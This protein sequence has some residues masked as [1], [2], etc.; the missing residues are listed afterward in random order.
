MQHCKRPLCLQQKRAN[1]KI[2]KN[3]VGYKNLQKSLEIALRAKRNKKI[4]K[5][6]MSSGKS[7]T[8]ILNFFVARKANMQH[9]KKTPKAHN[10]LQ[11][12]QTDRP[13][14]S[15]E[16][17]RKAKP[18]VETCLPSANAKRRQ[19]AASEPAMQLVKHRRHPANVCMYVYLSMCEAR[20]S[21]QVNWHIY[22][23]AWAYS[24]T[25]R[26]SSLCVYACVCLW[27]EIRLSST[28]RLV[29]FW[30]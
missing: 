29:T 5:K 24:S 19:E 6:K 7:K 12:R 23:R 15:S 2:N 10:A 16:S 25:Q 11:R 9:A 28:A 13:R 18:A 21:S 17:S 22:V 14:S 20:N 26:T 27:K 30:R 1:R 8:G 4:K 3:T